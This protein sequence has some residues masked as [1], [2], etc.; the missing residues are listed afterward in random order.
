MGWHPILIT[1]RAADDR[2]VARSGVALSCCAHLTW[3][4]KHR[5][6]LRAA[7]GQTGGAWRLPCCR[8]TGKRPCTCHQQGA[9]SASGSP[10][11]AAPCT[12]MTA[13]GTR[14]PFWRD[15]GRGPWLCRRLLSLAQSLLQPLRTAQPGC[16]E[17]P[18]CCSET[19]LSRF[20]GGE[21]ALNSLNSLG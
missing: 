18:P 1:S 20:L 8:L 13:S 10:R 2:T 4:Q 9:V 5:C 19:A 6:V 16:A 11:P 15:E 17:E 3:S 14:P 21:A 12:M 7:G